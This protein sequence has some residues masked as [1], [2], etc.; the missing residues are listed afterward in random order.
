MVLAGTVGSPVLDSG[1]TG[2][3]LPSLQTEKYLLPLYKQG[4]SL[5]QSRAY[6]ARKSKVI[7]AGSF[8][9]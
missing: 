5:L 2:R 1:N 7:K 9:S 3:S 4:C 6:L 8:P